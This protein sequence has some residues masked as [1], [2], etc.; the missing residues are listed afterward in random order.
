MTSSERGDGPVV[1]G[2][3]GSP[4]ALDAVR[5]AAET[6][7]SRKLEL[8]I[9]HA[10]GY[11]RQG[12]GSE[13]WSADTVHAAFRAEAEAA[14]DEAVKAATTT[15][16]DIAI[17]PMVSDHPPAP[18]LLAESRRARMVVLG[19]TGL[20]GFGRL[21]LGSTAAEVATHASCPVVV[22]RRRSDDMPAAAGSPVVVGVDGSP[23]SERAIGT[24]FEEASLRGVPLVAVHAWLD[25]E[26]YGA[27]GA[28][29][30]TRAYLE[31][32]PAEQERERL[33]AE[34]LAGWPERYP[35]VAVERVVVLDRPRRQ[36]LERSRTASLLVVGSRGRGGFRG[37]VLGSVSQA[38]INH[39]E[40]PVMVVHPHGEE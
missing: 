26:Y 36:L 22:T 32:A 12:L 15:A 7:A 27:Y 4:S 20:G 9:V 2:V 23:V 19:A 5:W 3:D 10:F 33:L 37:L 16:A 34:R 38:L 24:A 8:R 39:A 28:F 14:L 1:V 6:A 29:H 21:L 40:C 25:I 13:L 31:S 18:L 17:S 11:A 35:D 30:E